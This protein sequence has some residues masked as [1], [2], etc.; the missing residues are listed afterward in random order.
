MLTALIIETL[1]V[2][3]DRPDPRKDGPGAE[4]GRVLAGLRGGIVARDR[5]LAAGDDADST[6]GSS[7]PEPVGPDDSA[8]DAPE[9]AAADGS[10][11]PNA[12]ALPAPSAGDVAPFPGPA[13][14]L[15]TKGRDSTDDQALAPVPTPL[16]SPLS[17]DPVKPPDEAGVLSGTSS[18]RSSLHQSLVEARWS[19][20]GNTDKGTPHSDP[21]TPRLS[22]DLI[23]PGDPSRRPEASP[24]Q[25]GAVLSPEAG[26]LRESATPPAANDPTVRAQTGPARAAILRP[27]DTGLHPPTPPAPGVPRTDTELRIAPHLVAAPGR[28]PLASALDLPARTDS[29]PEDPARLR[30]LQ[31]GSYPRVDPVPGR[32]TDPFDATSFPPPPRFATGSVWSNGSLPPAGAAPRAGSPVVSQTV[33]G[34]TNAPPAPEAQLPG[35]AE[36]SFLRP[37]QGPD[38]APFAPPRAD[39]ARGDVTRPDPARA[40]TP[41]SE[42]A[43]QIARQIADALTRGDTSTFDLVLDPEELGQV[44][45]RLQM[46]DGISL[47]TIHTER[48]ET[49][50]LMRRHIATLEQDLR[51]QGHDSLSLRFSG[52]SAQG[53]GQARGQGNAPGS[54]PHRD[55]PHTP[56]PSGHHPS[57][58]RVG[59]TDRLDLRL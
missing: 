17:S 27:G 32:N 55:A 23:A 16:P 58:A 45:M 33:D 49:L 30:P 11:L 15:V 2:A 6:T 59:Q 57:P 28:E 4:F 36:P 22:P 29:T 5:H 41:R 56:S 53:E 48:A 19:T 8:E 18:T 54:G 21:N 42:T 26:T 44:R 31:P 52:G 20:P 3:P 38:P 37:D 50:D 7:D 47:L 25:P 40:E 39:V 9:P 10:L 14:P 24:V 13:G 35:S 46:Q 51:S 1:S 43:V 12:A 34:Q